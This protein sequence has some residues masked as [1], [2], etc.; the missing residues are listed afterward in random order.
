MLGKRNDDESEVKREDGGQ[1][2]VDLMFSLAN[3]PREGETDHLIVELKRPS[4]KIDAE[5]LHQIQSYAFAVSSDQRFDKQ[6]THWKFIAVSDELDAYVE[7][8]AH[9]KDRPEGQVFVD[10]DNHLEVWVTTWTKVIHDAETRLEFINQA[11]SYDADNDSSKDFLMKK[12]ERFIPKG[13][14]KKEME[15]G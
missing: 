6:T 3:K 12:Y 10:N 11:L 5:V 4:K 7:Q 13:S 9:Q 14:K 2:R 8:Q 15:N 1:G